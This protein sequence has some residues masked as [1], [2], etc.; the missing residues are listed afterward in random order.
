MSDSVAF[1]L[2]A[3]T[4]IFGTFLSFW[5]SRVADA[6]FV[7]WGLSAVAVSGFV[8]LASLLIAPNAAGEDLKLLAYIGAFLNPG[9]ILSW[10]TMEPI[11]LIHY[12]SILRQAEAD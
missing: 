6:D 11:H 7:T 12:R 1:A 8:V 2:V 9:V 10:A 3:G 5:L 4:F